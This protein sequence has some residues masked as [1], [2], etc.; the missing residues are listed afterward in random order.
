VNLGA[1]RK[2]WHAAGHP[3][4]GDVYIRIPMYVAPTAEE[5][6]E[7]PREST[8]ANY[9]RRGE[10][11]AS[12]TEG[13]GTDEERAEFARRLFASDYDDL[14]RTRLAYGTPDA[15]AKRLSSLS[16]ELGLSGFLLEPNVGGGIPRDKVLRS[17]RLMAEQVAPA[18]H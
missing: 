5:A 6:Y 14:L 9:R 3:G 2:A 17:V 10:G 4:D 13:A 16:D 15:V 18:L 8:V 1:Y 12:R 11:Y 7:D